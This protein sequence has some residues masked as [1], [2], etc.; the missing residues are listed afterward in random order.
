[1][2]TT[3]TSF[4]TALAS[5]NVTGVKRKYT[6]DSMPPASIPA[7]DMPAQY[8]DSAGGISGALADMD[9]EERETL[10][11]T[12]VIVVGP[13]SQDTPGANYARTLGIMDALRSALEAATD[14]LVG[15]DYLAPTW[16][17]VGQ[18][19]GG[20]WEVRATVTAVGA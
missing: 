15:P 18:V 5:L 12:L 9:G 17:I 3:F 11:A 13:V 2:A 14:T 6:V 16:R 7:S 20:Y 1:M 4:V 8:I 10:Q 19:A